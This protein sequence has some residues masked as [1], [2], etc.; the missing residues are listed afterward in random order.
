MVYTKK[1]VVF[2][3]RE[4][5]LLPTWGYGAAGMPASSVIVHQP[6]NPSKSF[7]ITLITLEHEEIVLSDD[8]VPAI[9]F[10]TK[11]VIKEMELKNM[12]YKDPFLMLCFFN[13][14][15]I[16][17]S[18]GDGNTG[19]LIGNFSAD[20]YKDSIMIQVTLVDSSGGASN[21]AYTFHG[22]EITQYQVVAEEG[23]LLMENVKVKLMDM[24]SN[25]QA[26][27]SDLDFDD[28]STRPNANWD[29]DAPFL[30]KNV[31]YEWGGVAPVG[32]AVVKGTMT[33]SI[34]REQEHTQ[35]SQKASQHWDGIPLKCEAI[36]D[37]FLTTNAQIAEV[38]KAYASKTKQTFE[39][40]YNDAGGTEE[41]KWQST[42]MYLKNYEFD[43]DAIPEGGKPVKCK[44]TFTNGVADA[45]TKSIPSYSG[46]FT[47]HVDPYHATIRRINTAGR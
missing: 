47:D 32:I 2:F 43:G 31:S 41:R 30:S 1:H 37:G 44:L 18:W 21:F 8:N 13:N 27:T 15:T 10:D 20:T 40:I 26:F 16:S 22:G 4:G 35:G 46:K 6:L 42:Q 33:F 29:E 7:S 23:K 14:K 9:V 17:A 28:G 38:I 11:V 34:P 19:T 39:M 5:A 45:G 24:V 3:A 36:L 25:V 12:Y